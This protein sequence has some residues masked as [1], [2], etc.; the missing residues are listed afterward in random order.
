MTAEQAMHIIAVHYGIAH[1]SD[2]GVATLCDMIIYE[3]ENQL[4]RHSKVLHNCNAE[5]AQDLED[6]LTTAA[7]NTPM[8]RLSC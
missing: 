8:A 7:P 2:Y 5:D 6:Y 1:P 4:V 3:S